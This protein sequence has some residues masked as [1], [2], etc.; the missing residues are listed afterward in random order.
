MWDVDRNLVVEECDYSRGY[1]GTQSAFAD[2]GRR[3]IVVIGKRGCHI[4]G[5]EHAVRGHGTKP[6]RSPVQRATAFMSSRA[7]PLLEAVCRHNTL[8][9][10][11]GSMLNPRSRPKMLCDR[12]L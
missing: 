8:A 9:A 10:P 1:N 12:M 3:V 11:E 4:I 7:A 2:T 6:P 5:R